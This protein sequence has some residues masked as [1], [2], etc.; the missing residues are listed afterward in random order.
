MK[1]LR[2]Y[3]RQLSGTDK[4]QEIVVVSRQVLVRYPDSGMAWHLLGLSLMQFGDNAGALS[5]ILRAR[6]VIPENAELL[7]H[8]GIVFSRL[9]DEGTADEL[10]RR[11]IDLNSER[12]VTWINAAKNATD[13]GRFVAAR[14]YAATAVDKDPTEPA[15]YLNLGM[16]LHGSGLADQALSCY[17]KALI[18]DSG[19][20][21]AYNNMGITLSEKDALDA[22]EGCFRTAL[23]FKPEF[24]EALN[25]LGGVIKDLGR[26]DEALV[27]LLRS[28]FLCPNLAHVHS[29]YLL[30]TLY[31]QRYSPRQVFDAHLRFADWYEAPL[32]TAWTLH[33]NSCFVDRRLKVGYVSSDFRRH[34]VAYFIEPVLSNHDKE[35]FELYCYD[36]SHSGD[37]Y[38][39]RLMSYVGH[40]IHCAHLT[41]EQLAGRIRA[42][43]IDILVDL[44]GHTSGNRSLVFARKPA[45]IQVG[46]LGYPSTTGLSCLDFRLSHI[47]ADPL[48][49]PV[50]S[51]EA[52][53]RL[54]GSAWC[55]RPPYDRAEELVLAPEPPSLDKGFVSFAS[56]N[57]SAK[58]TDQMLAIWAMILQAVPASRLIIAD[59][60]DTSAQHR[61]LQ[62]FDVLGIDQ[63]RVVFP[64]KLPFGGFLQLHRQVDIALDTFPFNGGTTSCLTLWMGVPIVSM[65]G[66]TFAS[67]MGNMILRPLNLESLV[68]EDAAQYVQIAVNLAGQP[69]LLAALRRELRERFVESPWRDEAGHTAA[70]E[71]AY[72]EMWHNWCANGRAYGAD[73]QS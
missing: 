30:T 40:W 50:L 26:V 70:L 47:D 9:R 73:M 29:N 58:I 53:V 64:G 17:Q 5:T 14:R 71:S 67:R 15:G 69:K 21:E 52:V 27:V 22:A 60:Q 7:D 6:A 4:F 44:S 66:L 20:V 36:C 41:D 54:P 45:P 48:G 16:A 3:L 13:A 12:L 55:F 35:R 68:A 42:D 24:A 34:S 72:R 61:L 32:R 10:F 59:V 8:C 62:N 57:K 56:L 19:L 37:D 2:A 33:H 49:A 23:I 11:S 38:T 28:V 51:S 43:Q 46:Y 31:S 1:D 63:S 39:E 25:N 18:L 65:R